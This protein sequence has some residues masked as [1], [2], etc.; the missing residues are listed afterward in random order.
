MCEYVSNIEFLESVCE[1]NVSKWMGRWV[2]LCADSRGRSRQVRFSRSLT[3]K[4]GML[5]VLIRDLRCWVRAMHWF[6]FVTTKNVASET[7]VGTLRELTARIRVSSGGVSS[8]SCCG[9]P[10]ANRERRKKSCRSGDAHTVETI[11]TP[12]CSARMRIWPGRC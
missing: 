8:D 3:L 12:Y 2:S 1:T 11:R 9:T 5:G 7:C 4:I 6:F 10:H